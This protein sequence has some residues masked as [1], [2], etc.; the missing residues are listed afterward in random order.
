MFAEKNLRVIRPGIF[1]KNRN[2][3]KCRL[4]DQNGNQMDAVYFGDVEACLAQM[5]KKPVM[6]FTYYPAV[7][8]YM[9]RKTLQLTIVNYQ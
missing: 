2:V 4:E 5:E 3:L 8:E 7:N 1:G 9:G 6:S